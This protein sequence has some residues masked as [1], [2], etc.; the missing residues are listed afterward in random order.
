MWNRIQSWFLC[1]GNHRCIMHF[2]GTEK[3]WECI[4]CGRIFPIPESLTR[5]SG[6]FSPE[7]QERARKRRADEQCKPTNTGAEPIRIPD[8]SKARKKGA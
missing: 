5:V 6:S 3:V 4:R 8:D 2:L 7:A 1:G